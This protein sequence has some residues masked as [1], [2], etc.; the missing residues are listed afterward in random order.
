MLFLPYRSNSSHQILWN[1]CITRGSLGRNL[2]VFEAWN[3]NGPQ[4]ER[5]VWEEHSPNPMTLGR[6]NRKPLLVEA[7]CLMCQRRENFRSR[8][9]RTD[10]SVD[11]RGISHRECW[12]VLILSHASVI[13]STDNDWIYNSGGGERVNSFKKGP[14]CHTSKCS[15]NDTRACCIKPLNS[16][17]RRFCKP[18]SHQPLKYRHSPTWGTISL[19]A[20]VFC[21][22]TWRSLAANRR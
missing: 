16:S 8:S 19:V 3:R 14:E 18:P 17:A 12:D 9:S 6:T 1:G 13:L 22:L 21:N 15:R 4:Q 2:K 11:S 7:R 5:N 10:Y 20:P